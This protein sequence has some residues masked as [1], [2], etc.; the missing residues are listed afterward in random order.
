DEPRHIAE[1]REAGLRA[2]DAQAGILSAR[3][4]D[5]LETAV[6]SDRSGVGGRYLEAVADPAY[7]SAFGKMLADPQSGHLRFTPAEV[8]A[9]RVASAA[10]AQRN[11]N[12]TTGSAG[13]FAI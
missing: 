6:R 9:V 2:I 13:Q 7:N 4:G 5:R 10:E 1:G 11:L 12:V 3:A 8:E